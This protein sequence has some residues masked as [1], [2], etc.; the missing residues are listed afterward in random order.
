[1]NKVL[2][3]IVPSYR[4]ERY[5]NQTLPTFIHRSLYDKI[6]V[7]LIDDGSPDNTAFF[8]KQYEEKYPAIFK[9]FHKQNGGHGSVINYG[10]HELVNTKYFMVVDG[11]DYIDTKELIK[12]IDCIETINTDVILINST[13]IKENGL[14]I[15]HIFVREE[16]M[17]NLLD[18][19]DIFN[20]VHTGIAYCVY[21]TDIWK[22]NSIFL[23]EKVYYEDQQYA[24]FPFAYIK[25]AYLL[26]INVYRYVTGNINQS[27]SSLS[28]LK[29]SKHY[30]KVVDGILNFQKRN[31]FI[32]PHFVENSTGV[33]I[34]L[35]NTMLLVNISFN[36]SPL[37]CYG[38]FKYVFSNYPQQFI[39][40]L[41]PFVARIK[42]ISGLHLYLVGLDITVY[43]YW[44]VEG[45]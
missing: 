19:G 35:L 16:K 25:T 21:K 32:C 23:T 40:Q 39:L 30:L 43:R 29:N 6:V 22:K 20:K 33:A 10:V 12:L 3:I 9:Y 26:P 2:S 18:D 42:N 38:L 15:P 17:L 34:T 27:I 13:E 24:L 11:D 14:C 8:L 7:F 44:L 28:I 5:I 4:T 45:N 41:D 31:N 37:K 36:K 1:M